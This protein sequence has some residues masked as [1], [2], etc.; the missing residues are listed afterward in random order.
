MGL[1]RQ[2]YRVS[3]ALVLTDSESLQSSHVCRLETGDTVEALGA[4]KRNASAGLERV[5]CRLVRDHKEGW[6][7]VVGSQ[8]TVY[9]K[10]CGH[11]L[12]C[13]KEAVMTS[14]LSVADS[15]TIR[16]IS[17]GE[18]VEVLEF[19]RKDASCGVMR[20]KGR[21]VRDGAVGW[22]STAGNQGTLFLVP[23]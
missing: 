10:P 22:I 1:T 14:E 23:C 6:A 8:G 13:V 3:G 9:L 5:H 12:A 17:K 7:T 16:R 11:F 21:A 4:A 15:K 20:V 18:I 2:F 19:D